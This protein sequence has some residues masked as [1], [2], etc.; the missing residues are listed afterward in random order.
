MN[1][2]PSAKTLVQARRANRTIRRLVFMLIIIICNRLKSIKNHG[3]K[4]GGRE[5]ETDSVI[6]GKTY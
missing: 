1:S 4:W 6:L 3:V 5:I 2:V